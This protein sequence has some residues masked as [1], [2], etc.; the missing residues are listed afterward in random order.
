[1]GIKYRVTKN[2]VSGMYRLEESSGGLC[3]YRPCVEYDGYG[4]EI[5]VIR[6]TKY[7]CEIEQINRENERDKNI[8]E[9]C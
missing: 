1:M 4:D 8:W 6:D 9:V 2:K 5:P 7:K 3:E